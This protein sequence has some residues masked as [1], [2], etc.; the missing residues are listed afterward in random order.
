[1]NGYFDKVIASDQK[2]AGKSVKNLS[3][4]IFNPLVH[5]DEKSDVILSHDGARLIKIS[6][7]RLRFIV[8]SLFNQFERKKIKQGQTVLL[9]SISGNN[10][11]FIALMFTA[12]SAYGVR[13]LLPMFMELELLEEWL[14]VTSCSAIVLPGEEIMSLNHHE[15]EK[16]V[17][18]AI[19]NIAI[20]RKISCLD[21]LRDFSL[22]NLLYKDIPDIA[23]SSADQVKKAI[24]T[25]D[26]KTEAMLIS[27][28]GS[29]GK[30]KL[31]VYEQGAFIRCC[32]SW[33]RARFF[34]KGKLGGRGFTPLFTHTMGVRAY[35]N[36]LW[37]GVPVCL[38][39]TEWFE[40]KPETVRYFLLQMRPEHITGGPSVFNLLLELMR[41]FPEL[42]DKLGSYLRTVVSSGAPNNSQ[43]A[44]AIESAFGL[45]MHNAFGM[46]ETQQILSTLLIEKLS[47]EGLKSLGDPLPGVT[48]GLKKLGEQNGFYR[49]YV[50]SPFGYKKII[51]DDSDN[52]G[53]GS[54][55]NT[56]DIVSLDERNRI[57]Y[58]GRENRDFIKD[59]F[60]VKIPLDCMRRYYEKLY[61]QAEHVEYFPIKSD[62]GM[63]AMIFI[64]NNHVQQGKVTE[65]RVIRYYSRLINEVNA[66]LY[67][68]LEPFEFRHRFIS[69]FVLINSVVPKT[70]KGNVSKY[71][72]ETDYQD[73]IDDLVDPLSSPSGIVNTD[74]REYI[75]D[76]FTRYLNPYIGGMLSQLKMDY[77]YCGAKKDTLYS[78]REGKEIEILDFAG[79]YGTNL[80]GHNNPELKAAAASFL[81]AD[82][83][84]LSDQGSIQESAGEL[85]AELEATIGGINGRE[86]NVMFGSSGAEAVEMALHHAA[87][88]WRKAIERIEQQ[89][90]Q[91]LGENAGHLVRE[92]WEEN[93]KIIQR[94]PLH[95]LT[96]RNAF[97]GNSA[98]PRPLLGNKENREIFSNIKGFRAIFIDD[99]SPDWK[100]EIEDNLKK[101]KIKIKKVV[102][103]DGEYKEV[104]LQVSTVIAA[105]AEPIIGEGGV[106]EVASDF[107]RHLASYNF[108]LIVDE[109]QCGLGRSGSFLA[110]EGIKADYYLFAKALGGG[111]ERISAVLIDKN[112]YKKEFGKLYLS[113]FSNGGLAAKIGL[114]V[115]SI[116]K[117]DRVSERARKQG[118]K[119]SVKLKKVQKKYPSVIEGITG[120]G[121]MQGIKF[122][123]FSGCDNILLR[124]LFSQ[125]L[126]GYLFSSYLLH[127]HKIRILPTL[128]APNTLRIEPSAY[129]EDKE[130]ERFVL[131]IE[132]LAHQIENR[133]M[134]NL[135]LPLMDDDPFD[136][137]KGKKAVPGQVYSCIDKP[138]ASSVRVAF[139]GHFVRPA[140]ELR[141]VEKELFRASDTGLRILFNRMQFLM[142]M[143]PVVLFSKNLFGGRIHFSF[144]IVPLDSAQLERLHRQGKR[145]QVVAK[146]QD[147]VDLAASRGASVISLGGYTSILSLNG[148][149]LVEPKSAKIITGNT[150]TAASGIHRLIEEIKKRN[151]FRKK[152]RLGIIGAAGNIG[153]ILASKLAEHD[154]LFDKIILINKNRQKLELVVKEIK[155]KKINLILEIATDFDALRQCDIIS[156]ATNTND[157]IIFPHHLKED[158]PVLISDLSVPTA[159]S[160]EAEKMKNVSTL[161]FASYIA[162]SEDPEF[163]ISSYTPKGSVFCCAAEAL[164][165]GLE[166]IDIPLRGKITPEAINLVTAQAKKYRFFEKLGIIP[167]FK[168]EI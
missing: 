41:N 28:S 50:N 93:R 57:I 92:V 32:L 8:F 49:L 112:R 59:G 79:G 130:I 160:A 141:M 80:L 144:I 109:I 85:A 168:Q 151:E 113:T 148:S 124:T 105:I 11:L 120:R 9:A 23:Y 72:I 101:A 53:P 1:M 45:T 162:L 149:S 115:L 51:G 68:T 73:V 63:A 24:K 122:T 12:L 55:F 58:Q 39:N 61:A 43:T 99:R 2:I 91:H 14:D 121:L 146:I 22:K 125:K 56:G 133:K 52:G 40:E 60:G 37:T 154:D 164:L 4:L 25:T 90:F 62:P 96:L 116:I 3:S 84:A 46:T 123:D 97:H 76:R 165:C 89:Q 19:G 86:Y 157:P 29:S 7:K 77:T 110:S 139:I 38:I 117:N 67:K 145:R 128:S 155:A 31:V 94:T 158:E 161:P 140:E 107:M 42:K 163:I 20:R 132:D 34:E 36:A 83:I 16:S 30:S 69:R 78:I 137:N 150:L 26:H 102:Y 88:E 10:E 159:V 48:L 21:I 104:D 54:F 17:V 126:S 74:G 65:E 127:R 111:I 131:A 167:S 47:P 129:I 153:S 95:V 82:E 98:G 71:K 114:K 108:P 136:D 81:D 70:V 103:R 135:L 44:K 147:A 75:V 87:L 106:R 13:V 138:N 33:Q 15:K 119:I 143:K 66:R 152:N 118:Q 18:Q 6:L 5:R 156:V 100:R 134:Y 64:Q 27:T 142:E 35:F 166:P